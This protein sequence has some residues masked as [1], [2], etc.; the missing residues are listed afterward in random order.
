MGE[1]AEFDFGKIKNQ[2]VLHVQSLDSGIDRVMNEQRR[3][4]EFRMDMRLRDWLFLC[5]TK[6][7]SSSRIPHE[8]T[9][10]SKS[11]SF[12]K[13]IIRRNQPK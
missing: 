5:M 9:D 12:E 6:T 7:L 4:S 11:T 10:E 8:P 13:S 1:K 2:P 3:V